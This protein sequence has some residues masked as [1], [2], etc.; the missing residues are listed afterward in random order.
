MPDPD[1]LPSD[2]SRHV[3]SLGGD[4]FV[5]ASQIITTSIDSDL[6]TGMLFLAIV[7]ANV[8]HLLAEPDLAAVYFEPGDLPPEALRRPVSVYAIAR[9]LHLPYETARR[10]IGK[11]LAS[12]LCVRGGDGGVVAPAEVNHRED[13]RA[14]VRTNFEATLRFVQALADAGVTPTGGPA[15][16]AAAKSAYLPREV[17]RLSSDYFLNGVELLMTN[18]N[19]Q[20]AEGLMFLA[21]VGANT[22]HATRDPALADTFGGVDESP[23]DGPRRTVSIY[24]LAR[25]LRL[26]YETTRRHVHKLISVGICR[27]SPDRGLVAPAEVYAREDFKRGVVQTFDM[28]QAFVND[29]AA[30]GL[31]VAPTRP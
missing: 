6:V 19:L 18:M 2:V 16:G 8:R 25:D 4:F 11:L 3:M 14:A 10:H 28:T 27:R 31:V 9:E 21:I 23:D 1:A 15:P 29:L 7:R 13:V 22:R 20:L 26:P 5:N 17:V 30:A 12:G 24:N